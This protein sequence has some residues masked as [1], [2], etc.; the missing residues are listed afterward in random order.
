MAFVAGVLGIDDCTATTDS[1]YI[2]NVD[3]ATEGATLSPSESFAG[4]WGMP[5]RPVLG[6][7]VDMG[8][9]GNVDRFLS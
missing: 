1:T 4:M 2:V 6:K 3:A 7:R 9:L 5:S 8:F